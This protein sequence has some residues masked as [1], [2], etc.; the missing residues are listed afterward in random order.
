MN[1]P[2]VPNSDLYGSNSAFGVTNHS[3]VV[4]M[5]M[6]Q[7][8]TFLSH[9]TSLRC[10]NQAPLK[11]PHAL[12]QYYYTQDICIQI[13]TYVQNRVTNVLKNV[14]RSQPEILLYLLFK[15][16]ILFWLISLD[17]SLCG[18]LVSVGI[19]SLLVNPSFVLL[20]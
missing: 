20:C 10:R 3:E 19:F 13:P 6:N 17:I 1:E 11:S 16:I 5:Q 9:S 7:M 4:L 12:L 18:L 8:S 14:T 2:Q 15:I